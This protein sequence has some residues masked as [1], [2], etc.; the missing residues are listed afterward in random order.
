MGP[1]SCEGSQLL[2]V[3]KG[4]L[5]VVTD[6]DKLDMIMK[7]V[8]SNSLKF[9]KEAASGLS[10]AVKQR[11]FCNAEGHGQGYPKMRF[12]KFSRGSSGHRCRR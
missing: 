11:F 12:P 2:V 3:G 5:E 8:L 6:V 7:N 10:M 1:Y 4:D 9:T